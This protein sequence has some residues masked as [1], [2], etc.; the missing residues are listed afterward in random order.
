MEMNLSN[1]QAVELVKRRPNQAKI[2]EGNKYQSRLRVFTL[3]L[4]GYALSNE[5]AWQ[6]LESSLA[7]KLTAEKF[8]A[9]TK[10]YALPLPINNISNDIMLDLYKV[11]DGRNAHFSVDYPNDRAKEAAEGMLSMLNVRNWIEAK[12]KRVLKCAPNT[13]VVLDKDDKGEPL[14]LAIPNE[15]IVGYQDDKHGNF[16][17][18]IFIHSTGKTEDGK[19]WTKYAVYDAK[20]YRVVLEEK[21]MLSEVLDAPHNLGYCPAKFFFDKPL[22][23]EHHF[24]RCVPLSPVRGLMKQYNQIDLF[25]FYQDNFA[26]FQILQHADDD[27]DRGCTNGQLYIE[28]I[29]NE[30]NVVT[31]EG[32]HTECPSCANKQLIGPGTLVGV[33]VGTDKED[34]DTRGLT[35]FIAPDVNSLKYTGE[36]QAGRVN[37]IK[38]NTTGYNSALSR[39]AMNETQVMA[40]MESRKKPLLD[41]ASYLNELYKWIVKGMVKLVYNVDV[42]VSA[43]FG[44]EF[45]ILT[46]KEILAVIQ[47]AKIAGVQS[48]EIEQLNKLLIHTKYKNNPDLIQK[49]LIAKDVE[50]NAFDTQIE[51]R[52]KFKEFMITKEDYYIKSNFNDLLGQF[53]RENGSIVEFGKD[54]T[55]DKKIESIKKTL[56]HYTKQKLPQDES[57]DTAQPTGASDQGIE[58]S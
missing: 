41:I 57:D 27:C 7:N 17:V 30:D 19:E 46:E 18:F 2:A 20:S 47:Q 25:E 42:K 26:A 9:I 48:T 31:T 38:V 37:S 44:T 3:P 32:Y 50:P 54:L 52:D 36:K 23:D 40:I 29:Q 4:D 15:R 49:M 10:Y 45:F 35:Q 22:I 14:L 56:L 1:S 13:V 43:S 11:F 39:E 53:E 12:G 58:Q 33:V 51:A 8:K 5:T 55:Y 6:E 34:Q 16:T 24:D 21:G 28:P